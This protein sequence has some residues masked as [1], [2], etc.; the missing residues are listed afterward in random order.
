MPTYKFKCRKCE[1]TFTVRASIKEKS[2]GLSLE[3]QSCNSED[4]FQLFNSIGVI[5]KSGK[6]NSSC[7]SCPPGADCCG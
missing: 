5:G 4:V 6:K 2:E 3:C 7:Q 1:E